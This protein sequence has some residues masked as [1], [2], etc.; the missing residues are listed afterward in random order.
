MKLVDR[1]R[2]ITNDK[3]LNRALA[4]WAKVVEETTWKHLADVRNT[5]KTADP[6][7]GCVV[8]NIRNNRFRLITR[9]SYKM[10][11][12]VVDAVLTHEEYLRWSAK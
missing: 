10:A 1:G 8:F 7:K 5:Y 2:L 9:I 4:T 3:Q 11:V 12:V 6:V